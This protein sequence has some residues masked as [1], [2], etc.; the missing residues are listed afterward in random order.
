MNTQL[1]ENLALQAGLIDKDLSTPGFPVTDFGSCSKELAAFASLLAKACAKLADDAEVGGPSAGPL[2]R[3]LFCESQ[4]R[5][6]QVVT[7]NMKVTG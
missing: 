5:Q 4:F 1:I 3:R 2:I 7:R 6:S